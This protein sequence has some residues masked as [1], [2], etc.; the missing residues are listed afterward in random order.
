MIEEFLQGWWSQLTAAVLVI[1]YIVRQNAA[2]DQRLKNLEE[3][4]RRQ[5]SALW[6][7]HNKIIDHL[8]NKRDK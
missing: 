8:L 5:M 7:A 4:M 6:D 1:F 2:A 3:E